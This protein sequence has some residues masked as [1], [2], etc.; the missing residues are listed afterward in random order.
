[1]SYKTPIAGTTLKKV[2]ATGK[3]PAKYI[4]HVHALLDDA[5]VSLLAAVAEQLHDEMDI[6]RDA[7]WKNYRSLAREVKSKR[8]IWE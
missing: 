7:V 4:P 3:M 2:L 1:V 8:G 6:S 5:P